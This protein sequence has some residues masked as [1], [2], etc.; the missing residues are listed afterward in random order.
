MLLSSV[1]RRLKVLGVEVLDLCPG[2]FDVVAE[3]ARNV[4][5][6]TVHFT[7]VKGD[8]GVMETRNPWKDSRQEV[9]TSTSGIYLSA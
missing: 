1:G 6:L 2:L 7:W 8:G 5:K 9:S 3:K 4:I